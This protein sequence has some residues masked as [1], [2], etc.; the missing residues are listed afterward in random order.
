MKS[1]IH[2]NI[3][4]DRLSNTLI[5]VT[6]NEVILEKQEIKTKEIYGGTYSLHT[7]WTHLH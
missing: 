7:Y 3:A 5:E 1:M 2:T 6:K 4:E